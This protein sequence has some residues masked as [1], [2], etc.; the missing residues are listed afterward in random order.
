MIDVVFQMICNLYEGA[1]D[2]TVFWIINH[3]SE[4]GAVFIEIEDMRYRIDKIKRDE[5]YKKWHEFSKGSP[6]IY[7]LYK[8]EING[9][10]IISEREFVKRSDHSF[11]R[12]RIVLRSFS[13][14]EIQQEIEAKCLQVSIH[15]YYN[16]DAERDMDKRNGQY[17]TNLFR[18]VGVVK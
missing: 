13:Q 6:Y 5:T 16:S 4:N 7:G 2:D 11:E 9:K 12:N 10:D 17:N 8:T 14:N 1:L 15:D 18:V 3:L